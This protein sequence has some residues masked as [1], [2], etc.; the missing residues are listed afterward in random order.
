M[1]ARGDNFLRK[2]LWY[3]WWNKAEIM[4]AASATRSYPLFFKRKKCQPSIMYAPQAENRN[5]SNNG[6]RAWIRLYVKKKSLNSRNNNS[7]PNLISA[8]RVKSHIVK[9]YFI[10]PL[11]ASSELRLWYEEQKRRHSNR[12]VAT[13][14]GKSF[15]ETFE[16]GCQCNLFKE[17][18]PWGNPL[19]T[20]AEYFG[21]QVRNQRP[22]VIHLYWFIPHEIIIL[23]R[24]TSYL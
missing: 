24:A 13:Q 4:E 2:K 11:K 10:F 18:D 19:K 1:A 8:V 17:A 14:A 3:R 6:I 5:Y 23:C 12:S 15:T 16:T 9:Y 21:W 22:Q 20:A 7:E